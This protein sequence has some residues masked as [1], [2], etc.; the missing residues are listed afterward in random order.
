MRRKRLGRD[1]PEVSILCL[2][3]MTW[4]TQTGE[5]EAHRQIDMALDHGVNFIDTA[6]MYPTNPVR[7]ATLGRTEDILG[8]WLTRSGRRGEV[9][10]ATKVT[11]SGNKEIHD[12]APITPAR[13]EAA[14]DASLR[15][16]RT[17]VIDIYQLHWPNRG[18]Y[19]F[20]QNWNFDPSGLERSAA[21]AHM[22]EVLQTL[23]RL[24]GAG[25][26]RHFGLSNET[27]WGMAQW[28]ARAEATGGP[29]PVS[30]Q[31]EYSLLCRLFDTDMAELS[32][33]ETVPLLAYSP[34]AAGLLTGKYAGDVIPEGSRR[35]A[36]PT[37]NGRTT[38]RVWEAIS[39]YFAVA[40]EH[41][42]DPVQMAL[43]FVAERPF[44]GSVILGASR[45]EHLERALGAAELDLTEAARTD[46]AAVHKAHPLPF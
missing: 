26:I 13:I 2:G 36:N 19:H 46:I 23:R 12:G 5:A 18:S 20:R 45:I 38:P 11:G 40:A 30:V 28:I 32:L 17:D 22:D 14:V 16:L 44:T 9:V 8:D 37:L 1:G 10:I 33:A 24:V 21:L 6:E 31:N 27:A 15:R 35:D 25:K 34:L 3:T 39:A 7:A 4:G 29:R 42:M 41:R 43:A